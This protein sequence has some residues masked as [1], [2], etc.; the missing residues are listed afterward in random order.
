MSGL[1]EIIFLIAGT[2]VLGCA[3]APPSGGHQQAEEWQRVEIK[4]RFSFSIPPEMKR[5][6]ASGIDSLVGEY[7]SPNISLSFD[8]GWYSDP[9]DYQG[10]T[11]YEESFIEVDG[12]K[13]KLVT[14]RQ[15]DSKNDFAN[16]AGIHFAD[17]GDDQNKLTMWARYQN[18]N[19]LDQIK[20]VFQSIK[21]IR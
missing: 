7:R 5:T 8:Y 13:A 14:F 16:F 4:G 2:L 15:T 20:R 17:P 11:N 12:R 1:Y 18:R 3:V 9:L 10:R 19:D 6:S 21:F